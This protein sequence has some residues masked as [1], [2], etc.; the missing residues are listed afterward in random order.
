[1][2]AAFVR[3]VE[4]SPL[5]DRLLPWLYRVVRNLAISERQAAVR[6]RRREANA[7]RPAKAEDADLSAADV[8]D[9]LDRLDGDTRKVVVAHLWGGLTFTEI[10][11]LTSSF[12]SAAHRRPPRRIRLAAR[13]LDHPC[14]NC[15]T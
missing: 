7:G 8:A 11:E 3:L 6:R 14:L 1:M 4:A 10:A 9:A 2:Q 13:R 15:T 5:P 12:A